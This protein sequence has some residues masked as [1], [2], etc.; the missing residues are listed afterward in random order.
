MSTIGQTA[1]GSIHTRFRKEFVM[2]FLTLLALLVC[3]T[4]AA[5]E[6]RCANGQCRM[7]SDTSTAQG[8]AEI[9]ARQGRVGHHG[10]NRGYEGC[11]SGSSPAAAL[12]NCCYARNGWPVIDQG[13]AFGHGR[14]FA[15][16]RYGR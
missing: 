16:R 12:A 7:V 3:S 6:L 14:W 9:Q 8:V 1:S 15:C 2:R 11:G 4:A 13:V 10:G 5:Q